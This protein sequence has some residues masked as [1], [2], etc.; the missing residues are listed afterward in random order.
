[1]SVKPSDKPT[2]SKIIISVN[3]NNKHTLNT[4]KKMATEEMATHKQIALVF[5][6]KK[7]TTKIS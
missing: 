4:E 7:S 1:M 6:K 5:K 2:A 3:N